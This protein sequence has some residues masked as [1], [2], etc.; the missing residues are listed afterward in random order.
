MA[1]ARKIEG[2]RKYQL[3]LTKMPALLPA[4][5]SGSTRP[6]RSRTKTKRMKKA[7]ARQDEAGG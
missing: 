6:N 7:T 5:R 3:Y 1:V 4:A 2:A